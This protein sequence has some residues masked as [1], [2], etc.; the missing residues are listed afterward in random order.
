MSQEKDYIGCYFFWDYTDFYK[1]VMNV[2]NVVFC[3][4]V[5]GRGE[6]ALQQIAQ[7]SEE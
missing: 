7:D 6:H 4:G 3:R 1:K 2:A 5:A